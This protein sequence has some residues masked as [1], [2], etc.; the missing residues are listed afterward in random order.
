MAASDLVLGELMERLNVALTG[1][2]VEWVR[3]QCRFTRTVGE[4]V[5]EDTIYYLAD[6]GYS[7]VVWHGFEPDDCRLGLTSSSLEGP[8]ARWTDP[9]VVDLRNQI[10]EVV[11]NELRKW[12]GNCS[13]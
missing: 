8:K 4:F 13:T 2:S 3:Q 9:D 6:G 1:K 11:R 5:A 7:R 10:E 12:Q